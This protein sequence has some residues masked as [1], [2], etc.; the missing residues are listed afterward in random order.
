MT[1]ANN[2][3]P[4]SPSAKKKSDPYVGRVLD[5]SYEILSLLGQG[6]TTSVYKAKD[7]KHDRFAAVKIL[8]FQFGSNEGTVNRFQQETKTIGLLSHVNIAAYYDSGITAEDEHYLVLEFADGKNLKQLI[9]ETGAVSWKRAIHLFL[10]ICAALSAA[11]KLGIVHRDLKPA[12]IIVTKD[13]QGNEV[14]KLLDFGVA[15]L[16]LQGETF[17]TKTQT[18]EMLGT[19]LYMSPEQCLDQDLDGRSDIYSLGCVL[20]EALTGVPPFAARTAFETMNLHLTGLPEKLAKVRP[21]LKFPKHLDSCIYKALAKDPKRRYQTISAFAEDLN[22][23][24]KNLPVSL[25]HAVS[26]IT[27]DAQEKK[28]IRRLQIGVSSLIASLIFIVCSTHIPSLVYGSIPFLGIFTYLCFEE[29]QSFSANK[30]KTKPQVVKKIS[31]VKYVQKHVVFEERDKFDIENFAKS[32]FDRVDL[33]KDGYITKGEM[34]EMLRDDRSG[35]SLHDTT[36]IQFVL[37]HY[38][39][40]KEIFDDQE[41]QVGI[42]KQE[43]LEFALSIPEA[44]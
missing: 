19:L 42:S 38:S 15:K 25:E 29:W 40:F 23:I 30:A 13:A 8:H 33:N 16:L 28:R 34:K 4:N 18:G 17:Q 35:L 10:Q 26:T 3:H 43:I 20:F 9:Q 27:I 39:D 37:E 44:G 32:V 24:D 22:K 2:D 5:D 1:Q 36:F 41:E 11:H 21:E 14:I 31:T 7:T 12:N 6:A